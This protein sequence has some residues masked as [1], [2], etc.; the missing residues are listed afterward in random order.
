[1]G[2]NYSS[3]NK[4]KDAKTSYSPAKNEKLEKINKRNM[5]KECQESVL[6]N[7]K[8]ELRSN[9][10]NSRPTS[11]SFEDVHPPEIFNCSGKESGDGEYVV[12]SAT[13][14]QAPLKSHFTS[15]VENEP[16]SILLF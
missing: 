12:F 15:A 4:Y 6:H 13:E 16:K 11:E 1:M 10:L 7:K 2:N 14:I 9:S 5:E 3:K 8:A